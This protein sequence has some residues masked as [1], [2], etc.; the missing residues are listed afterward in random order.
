MT[1][2]SH[3]LGS[4]THSPGPATTA[5]PSDTAPVSVL[6][7]FCFGDLARAFLGGIVTSY[8]LV[9]FIPS[10]TSSLPVLIPAAAATLALVR[11]IGAVVD[12]LVDPLIA[13]R[14]DASDNRRGRRIP[15]LRWSAIPWA[16]STAALVL[17]PVPQQSWVNAV[18][19]GII[20][21]V[22]VVS[23]SLYT[24]PF[25]ALQAEI[26]TG[27]RRRVWF[28]TLNTL[29]YVIGSA[30][31]FTAPVIKGMLAATTLTEL[32]SWQL[33]FVL[34][35]VLGA[36]SAIVAATS[37]NETRWVSFTPTHVPLWESFAATFRYP[38]YVVLL[39]GYLV[40]WVA[41][42]L[43][44]ATLLYYITMLMGAP[45]A[46][47]AVVSGVAIV[48]GIASYWPINRIVAHIGK[49]PLLIGAC[50][51]YVFIYAAIYEYQWVLTLLSA[52][53][54]ALLIGVLIGFPISVTN[55]LPSAAFA[56]LT[57]YDTIT[58]GI[59]RAGMFY[60]SRNFITSLA[61][62]VVIA[63][64]PTLI[65]WGSDDGKATVDGVRLTAGVA[66]VA[67]AAATALYWF[68]DDKGI[69]AALDEHRRLSDA[70]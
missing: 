63:V 32:A 43:F 8:L 48:I 69:V 70:Q 64:T 5:T 57:E 10:S 54:F 50:L 55:I 56:D 13:A 65:A 3:E 30:V 37:V 67:I 60:A 23:S 14:S 18:W 46:F 49:K 66:A 31:V 6:I 40:M 29:F 7:R 58:T 33:T 44:N 16:V 59:N 28:Y 61:Q 1:D 39:A 62:T 47:A 35:S 25:N 19:V 4:E 20:L 2:D 22:N 26:V 51:S 17:V 9:V 38:N 42:S 52:E 24:V 21:L 36:I 68:Y 15:Y 27:Q 34:F 53:V 45:E 11:G 12:A 41:F